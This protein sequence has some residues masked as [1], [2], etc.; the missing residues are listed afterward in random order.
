MKNAPRVGSLFGVPRLVVVAAS[1]M[2][3]CELKEPG[4]PTSPEAGQEPRMDASSDAPVGAGARPGSGGAS[5]GGVSSGGR[6]GQGASVGEA[7]S[8]G[9]LPSGGL[10]GSGGMASEGGSRRGGHDGGP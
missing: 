10:S 4:L 9:R 1:I 2:V 8:G 5:S 7:G 6:A 3:A